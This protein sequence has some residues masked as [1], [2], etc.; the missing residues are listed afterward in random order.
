MLD[1]PGSQTEKQIV[2]NRTGYVRGCRC[3]ICKQANRDYQRK[4]MQQWR[5]AANKS[6]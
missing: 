3:D 6:E 1:N 4:Y 2:H 5:S